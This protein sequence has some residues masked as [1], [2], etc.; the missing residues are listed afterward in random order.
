MIDMGWPFKFKKLCDFITICTLILLLT[1]TV[2]KE[3]NHGLH[4]LDIQNTSYSEVE[5]SGIR[6]FDVRRALLNEI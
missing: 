5:H 2:A 3:T 6:S 1:I 4:K